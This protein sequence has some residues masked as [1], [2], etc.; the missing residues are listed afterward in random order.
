MVATTLNK[1]AAYAHK[2]L[3][4]NQLRDTYKDFTIT[5]TGTAG[6]YD[7]VSE[8]YTGGDPDFVETSKGM[9]RKPSRKLKDQM[10]LTEE[11][12]QVSVLQEMYINTS[13]DSRIIPQENDVITRTDTGKSYRLV[14]YTHDV[15]DVYWHM[16]VKAV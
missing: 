1:Q 9:F 14:K 13:D 3:F 11:M 12:V 7:P 6:T 15:T 10:N 4:R 5:R 2:H 8:T 16:F